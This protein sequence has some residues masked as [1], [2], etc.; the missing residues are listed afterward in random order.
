[1]EKGKGE[2][3]G[4]PSIL[5]GRAGRARENRRSLSHLKHFYI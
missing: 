2:G 3:E 1:M 5:L 4:R